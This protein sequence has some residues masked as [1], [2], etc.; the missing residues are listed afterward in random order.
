MTFFCFFRLLPA[1]R[2]FS[3]YR[4]KLSSLSPIPA[5]SVHQLLHTRLYCK[6]RSLHAGEC[7]TDC[8]CVYRCSALGDLLQYTV[9]VVPALLLLFVGLSPS[10][11]P[12]VHFRVSLLSSRLRTQTMR[13]HP[14]R[15]AWKGERM[16]AEPLHGIPLFL[17]VTTLNH[18][19][20]IMHVGQD[21]D[22]TTRSHP[23]HEGNRMIA[24]P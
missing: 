20:G 11:S 3:E 8:V 5:R 13:S 7:L 9:R 16:P 6:T 19:T 23:F 15:G 17:P 1:T 24:E 2:K 22:V 4:R 12:S 14:F 21:G 18:L 10:S